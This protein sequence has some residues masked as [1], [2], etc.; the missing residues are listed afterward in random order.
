MTKEKENYKTTNFHIASWLIM[1]DITL[2]K[3]EWKTD[4]QG[5]QRAEFG[6]KDFKDRDIL[7]QDFFKQDALQKKIAADTKLKAVMYA[8]H[9]PKQ[10]DRESK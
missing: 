2:E 3:V 9:P 4:A 8:V 1:N 7:I 10:Y 6:F 5:R